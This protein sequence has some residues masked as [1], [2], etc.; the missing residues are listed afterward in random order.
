MLSISRLHNGAKT[1]PQ[2]CFVTKRY[3]L[4][5]RTPLSITEGDKG[6]TNRTT[7]LQRIIF[8]CIKTISHNVV[9]LLY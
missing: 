3:F 8:W 1:V 2:S 9:D 7:D 5:Y 4:R 6:L